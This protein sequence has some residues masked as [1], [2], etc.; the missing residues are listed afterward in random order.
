SNLC[1]SSPGGKSSQALK[2]ALL[3]LWFLVHEYRVAVKIFKHHACPVG[4][5]V[6]FAMKCDAERFHAVILA[7]AI[8]CVYSEEGKAPRLLANQRQVALAACFMQSEDTVIV[9]G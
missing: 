3:S 2:Q 4:L 6:G 8:G 9:A 7:N 1:F 5:N